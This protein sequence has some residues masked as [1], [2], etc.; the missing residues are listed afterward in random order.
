MCYREM[1]YCTYSQSK[2]SANGVSNKEQKHVETKIIL[3][4]LKILFILDF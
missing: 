3:A 4:L 1:S 2:V